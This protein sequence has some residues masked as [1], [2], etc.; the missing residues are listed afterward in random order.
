MIYP[1]PNP[2]NTTPL[3]STSKIEGLTQPV[4]GQCTHIYL[5]DIDRLEGG[6]RGREGGRKGTREKKGEERRRKEGGEKG[7]GEKGGGEKGGGEKGGGEK[8]GE[9]GGIRREKREERKQTGREKGEGH[10]NQMSQNT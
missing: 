2:P 5:T 1:H 6:R 3:H 7:G 4:I 8:G 10:N 9:K